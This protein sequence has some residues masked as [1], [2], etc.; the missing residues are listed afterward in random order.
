METQEVLAAVAVEPKPMEPTADLERQIK[1]TAEETQLE[2][3]KRVVEEAVLA[4]LEL[5]ILELLE[6]LAAQE[7]RHQLQDQA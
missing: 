4:G 7:F 2:V 3:K 5:Q 6:W 1:V